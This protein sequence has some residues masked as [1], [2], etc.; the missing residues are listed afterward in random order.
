MTSQIQRQTVVDWNPA[1]LTPPTAPPKKRTYFN[2][3]VVSLVLS[4]LLVG[5]CSAESGNGGGTGNGEGTAQSQTPPPK[6]LPVQE[7][8]TALANALD[9]LESALKSLAKAKAYKGLNDRVASVETAADQAVTELS[10]ITPPAEVAAEH[11]QL[12]KALQAFHGE[13]GDLGSQVGDRALCTGSA[14]HAGL[15]DADGTSALRDALA[16]V[17]AKLP[18]PRPGLTLPAADQKVGSRPPNGKLIRAGKRDGQSAL[19]IDN[20]GSS[21]AVVTLSK[22]SKPAISVYV[23]KNKTT[24]VEGVPNG[25]YTVFFTFG[26]AWD[27]SARAFGRN[28]AFQRFRPGGKDQLTFQNEGWVITLQR[29]AGGNSPTDDVDPN[30]FP[31]S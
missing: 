25:S 20:G 14:V 11:S 24:T 9:P 4:V 28:C 2:P 5:G 15:G 12:V 10:P 30:D 21:D 23:R 19:D 18:K 8:V 13:L 26:A 27:A 17:S 1:C 6:A 16:A 29:V 31:D 22:G 3:L 7:Y